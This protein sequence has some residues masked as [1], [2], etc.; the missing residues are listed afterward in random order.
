LIR[1]PVISSEF[2][3][4]HTEVRSKERQGKLGLLAS[5]SSNT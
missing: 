1:V 4:V 2:N 3:D 5:P